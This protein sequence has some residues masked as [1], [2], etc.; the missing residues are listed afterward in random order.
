MSWRCLGPHKVV[1]MKNHGVAIAGGS[2]E[3][4]VILAIMLENACQIQLIVDAAGTAAP[5]FP[6]EQ[7]LDLKDKLLHPVQMAVNF[8]YLRRKHAKGASPSAKTPKAKSST[9]GGRR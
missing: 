9:R 6:R 8:E 3:E 1:L 7:I 4:A 2:I 5:E